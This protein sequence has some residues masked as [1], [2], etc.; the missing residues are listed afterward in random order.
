MIKHVL[1]MVM[2]TIVI[3]NGWADGKS[4]SSSSPQ[5]SSANP[6]PIPPG[7]F[8][9]QTCFELAVLHSETLGLREEDIRVAQAQYWQA[10]GTI[11]PKINIITSQ[12]Y[13]NSQGNSSTGGGGAIVTDSTGGLNVTGGGTGTS[14][15]QSRLNVKQPLF[16][17]FREFATSS[18]FKADVEARKYNKERS[19]Q[20]L[21][22]DVSDVFYQIL[23]YEGDLKILAEVQSTLEQRIQ[24]LDRRVRLGRSRPSELLTAQ[25]DLSNT[26]VAIEQVRG[27][28]G[29]SRELMSFLTAVPSRAL[30]LKDTQSIPSVDALEAYL[31]GTGERPDVLATIAEERAAHKRLSATK[32]ERLPTLSLE[33]NYYLIQDPSLGRDW[34]VFLTL[35]LPLF[36]GGII[37]AR[38]REQKALVR[39]SQLNLEQLRRTT[40]RDIRVAYSNFITSVAQVIRLH[41]G[42]KIAEQNYQAQNR[43]YDLGVVSNLDVIFALRQL[44][45]AKRQL[46]DA[47]ME[48]RVNMIRLHIAAGQAPTKKTASQ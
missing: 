46:F 23:M 20:L 27:L 2:L 40:D 42:Q 17:G 38:I 5:E 26:Q 36:A 47:E 48:T 44:S 8:D 33:G 31:T 6:V 21:Y 30:K 25:A 24:E 34:N 41:E 37:E 7:P 3:V 12:Q 4:I 18:A 15:F 16:S 28:L 9:L 22:L 32:G 10:V 13:Q 29:T 1:L 39:A 14:F 35:D 19:L 11:L 43:D 45:D